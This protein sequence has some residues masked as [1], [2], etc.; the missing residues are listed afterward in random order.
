MTTNETLRHFDQSEMEDYLH[1]NSPQNYA[2]SP[3][4]NKTGGVKVMLLFLGVLAGSIGLLSYFDK[5]NKDSSF[6][7]QENFSSSI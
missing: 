1:G 7:N 6:P 2:K 4:N 3:Q 5:V